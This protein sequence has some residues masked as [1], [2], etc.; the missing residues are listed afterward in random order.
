M[1][2]ASEGNLP[3]LKSIISLNEKRKIMSKVYRK[4]NS[5]WSVNP[6]LIESTTT[7]KV[8]NN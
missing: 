5:H 4:T 7:F 6:F 1:E 2:K 3:F 8:I